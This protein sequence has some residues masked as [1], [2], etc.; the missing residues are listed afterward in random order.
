L[1]EVGLHDRADHRP[2][3]LSGGEQQRIALARALITEPKVLMAD[4][5]TGD[6][7]G[8]SAEMV[9]DLITRL[10]HQHGLT[11]V[12]VTHNLE[13]ARRCGRVLR[14]QGGKLLDVAPSSLLER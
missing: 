12:I 3:E 10:H 5:P 8:K 6:L 2:G 1:K 7:D 13:F 9:F 14:L 11:S 4:E